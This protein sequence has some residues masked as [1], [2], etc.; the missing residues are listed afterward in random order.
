MKT[1]LRIIFPALLGLTLLF[2]ACG[3]ELPDLDELD[4]SIPDIDIPDLIGGGSGPYGTDDIDL[5]QPG[6]VKFEDTDVEFEFDEVEEEAVE[7][8]GVPPATRKSFYQGDKLVFSGY[9]SDS[10]GLD[11]LWFQFDDDLNLIVEMHD[12]DGDGKP[13]RAI[14]Y[15]TDENII[16]DEDL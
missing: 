14:Y 13:D 5:T 8:E 15:D 6:T 3:A 4:F 11:D 1:P 12:L 9:D 2:T 7:I 16:R 10:D